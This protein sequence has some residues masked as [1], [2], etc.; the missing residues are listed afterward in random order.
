MKHILTKDNLDLLCELENLVSWNKF[1]FVWMVSQFLIYNAISIISLLRQ[2]TICL[3][4]Q[5]ECH[6]NIID[7]MAKGRSI[8]VSAF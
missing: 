3:A 5:S 4:T 7:K 1:E 2:Q 6:K 8:Q